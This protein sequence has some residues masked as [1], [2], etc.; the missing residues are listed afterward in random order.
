MDAA[1]APKVFTLE[2]AAEI[3]IDASLGNYCRVVL[4][5]NR[6]INLPSN[7][8]DAQPLT[9]EII[10]DGTGGRTLTWNSGWNFGSDS[11][12]VLSTAPNK[13]DLAGFVYNAPAEEWFYLGA[14]SGY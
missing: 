2:D 6:T 8:T 5:G 13:R 4:G 1:I 9:I 12:P 11:S 3:D 14:R 10:Q 7:P